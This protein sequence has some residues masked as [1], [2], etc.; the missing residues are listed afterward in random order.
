M[1]DVKEKAKKIC[2]M[3]DE[4]ICQVKPMISQGVFC[5]GVDGMAVG[6]VVDM[7]KDLCEAEKDMY[8]ACYYKT[9]VEAM[10]DAEE[11]REDFIEMMGK[12]A[13]MAAFNGE[14]NDRM[15][16]DNW[17]YSSGRFAPKGSGH[18]AGYTD[19]KMMKKAY[20]DYY[21]NP[22][23]RNIENMQMETGMMGYTPHNM[24][25]SGA[26]NYNSGNSGYPHMTGMTHR[27]G[28]YGYPMDERYGMPY[29]EYE[30]AKKHYNESKDPMAKKEMEEHADKHLMDTIATTKA[31]WKDAKPER[32]KEFKKHMMELL[33][34]IPN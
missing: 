19:P 25:M 31:I 2:E 10:D 17:R 1:S 16:Y 3:K 6:Q 20:P 29:N 21:E 9:V 34:D 4:L 12:A 28:R 15:G 8:K 26:N 14:D 7:I 27:S 24:N 13:I 5:E 23:M 11:N 22:N 30:D 18:Y 32:Q 33:K